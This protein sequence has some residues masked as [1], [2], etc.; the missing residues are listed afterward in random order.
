MVQFHSCSVPNWTCASQLYLDSC[1]CLPSAL[2]RRGFI[3]SSCSSKATFLTHSTLGG[4]K[5]CSLGA[6]S[7]LVPCQPRDGGAQRR[8]QPLPR[9]STSRL[10][11]PA[12]AGLR[13][14]TE[15][16]KSK[17]I[18]ILLS[19]TAL[20]AETATF[21]TLIGMIEENWDP[22]QQEHFITCCTVLQ[23]QLSPAE[24]LNGPPRVALETLKDYK[25][26]CPEPAAAPLPRPGSI[27]VCLAGGWSSPVPAQRSPEKR[28]QLPPGCFPPG[29]GQG[30][31]QGSP[32]EA[33]SHAVHT[34]SASGC[35]PKTRSFV[36]AKHEMPPECKASGVC[37]SPWFSR[38][39]AVP[40]TAH[41]RICCSLGLLACPTTKTF[42]QSFPRVSLNV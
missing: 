24:G 39:R 5:A 1:V 31:K 2:I 20:S 27:T 26:T 35:H 7:S 11:L 40:G 4:L 29:K 8:A 13:C 25:S 23:I 37:S 16:E 28:G 41:C 19:N 9:G 32:C 12:P 30:C 21:I 33:T 36:P 15:L 10:T 14:R 38:P 6:I 34:S 18:P 42:K 22:V 17:L 3:V